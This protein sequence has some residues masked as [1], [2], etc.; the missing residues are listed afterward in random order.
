MNILFVTWDGPQVS[1]LESLFLPIFKRLASLG[2]RFHVLQFTWGGEAVVS[3]RR[4]ACEAVGIPY[5]SVA[6]WRKPRAL[7]LLTGFMGAA[8]I[9][10]AVRDF[11]IDVVMPR[12]TMPALATLRALK[13]IHV[14]M[15]FDADGLA[16]DERADF[17]GQSPS[18]LLHR[19]LRDVE[20]EA[21]RKA[22]TVLTRSTKA[23]DILLSRAGAG[24]LP[25]KFF[26][27]TNGRDENLFKPQSVDDRKAVRRSLGVADDTL[28]LVY[29]GSMGPQYCL[30]QMFSLLRRISERFPHVHLLVLTGSPGLVHSALGMEAD[31][32]T[33][34]SVKSVPFDEVSSYLSAADVG[35]ALRQSSFSMQAVAPVKLGEYLLCGLPVVATRAIG[36]TSSIGSDVG[37]LLNGH[38][39]HDLDA[40]ATWV[41]ERFMND[42]EATRLRARALG[43]EH[44]SLSRAVSD[45]QKA[46]ES[47]DRQGAVV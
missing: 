23:S 15:V 40:A 33:R 46:L 24:T 16:L 43:V 9:R 13:K 20:A 42:S 2:F 6:I 7:S 41:V 32:S 18:G 34:V 14:P 25:S 44:F 11:K 47:L 36:D 39:D 12:S 35:L 4:L 45:Y 26:E 8:D 37:F 5:R 38:A 22:H 28:V 17:A 29:A 31:I 21:V 10:K 27:V 30:P 1:Y 19:F 3:A